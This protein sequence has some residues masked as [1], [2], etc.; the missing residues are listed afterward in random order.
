ML[1]QIG[2]G[3]IFLAAV[4]GGGALLV[5]EAAPER[6]A[7][8]SLALP[9]E[10]KSFARICKSNEIADTRPDPAWV[11]ASFANDNCRAPAMPAPLDGFT[12]SR[13]QVM[14]GIAAMKS[15]T[16]ASDVFQRCV[17]EFVAVRRSGKN[18]QPM[19]M[20]LVIIENH[21]VIA[22]ENNKKKVAS[23]VRVAINAFNEYG[24][25]CAE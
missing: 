22:S 19:S 6:G 13:E 25:G 12:A 15:Y 11:G 10:G 3:A 23:R 16:A 24:S 5:A 4:A 17:Q 21:R 1:K 9:Q 20:P 18:K 8:T 2:I 14:A 7:A